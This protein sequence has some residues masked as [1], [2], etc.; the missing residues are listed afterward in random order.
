MRSKDGVLSV[1]SAE[2]LLVCGELHL[3]RLNASADTNTSR[4]DLMSETLCSTGRNH[5][6]HLLGIN[7]VV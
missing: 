2:L 3:K 5:H 4:L 1:D 7:T 6:E